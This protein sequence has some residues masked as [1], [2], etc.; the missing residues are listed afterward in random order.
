MISQ[1]AGGDPSSPFDE[2]TVVIADGLSDDFDALAK[3]FDH[4][5]GRFL[6]PIE[7]VGECLEKRTCEHVLVTKRRVGGRP[8]G[9]P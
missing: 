5:T 1:N 6:E 9:A 3:E 2:A 4:Y 8:A 7:W